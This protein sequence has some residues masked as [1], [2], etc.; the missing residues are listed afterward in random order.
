MLERQLAYWRERLA[1]APP[2]LELPAD[3][4]RPAVQ[5]VARRACARRRSAGWRAACAAFA[6]ASG[7]TPFMVLLAAFEALLLRYTGQDDLVVGTPVAGRGRAETEALIGFFVN[8]LALRVRVAG[9][10][11]FDALLGEVRRVT[12]E[13]FAH[14]DL[15]FEKLV[16]ELAPE[17]S[18]AHAPLFQV[19]LV[20]QNAPLPRLRLGGVELAPL[21]VEPAAAQFDLSLAVGEVEGGARA[22]WTYD[23]DLFDGATVERWMSWFERL[24]A[25]ALAD[26]GRRLA[27]LPLL[28]AAE[29]R[30]LA[31][32]N[33]TAALFPS[34]TCLHELIARQVRRTPAAPAVRFEGRT[35]SY[36]EL[37]GAANRLAHRLQR[38]G[39]G[40]EV[41]V[42]IHAERSLELVVGLL[43]VLKA[44][45]AYVPLDPGYPAE[46][47]A[48]M[49]ADAGVSVL[50]TRGHLPQL[51]HLAH[52]PGRGAE[53]VLL[54]DLWQLDEPASAPASAAGPDSLAYVI[55]TSGSTGRPKGAMNAHRGIVNRL[56]W[57]Q[58]QFDLGAGDRVLQKTPFSFD[59]SVWELFWPLLTGACLVVARPGG[60]QDPGYLVRTIAEEGITTLHF[61]PSMLQVFLEAPGLESCTSL[62]RVLASGEALPFELVERWYARTSVPLHNLY[63]PT[64]AAVDVTHWPCAPADARRLVPIGQ[65][66]WNTRIHLLDRWG[67]EVPVG[68]AGELH[69][70]GVQVGRGYLGRPELTAERFVPDGLGSAPGERQSD[71]NG[72][73]GARESNWNGGLGARLYRT[74]DLARRLPAGEVEYLGRLDFQVKVRGFR[75][76]PG[77]IEAALAA[78]PGVREAVVLARPEPGRSGARL[79]AYLVP[80]AADGAA[81]DG[82]GSAADDLVAALRGGLAERLPEHMVPQAFVVLAELPRSPNG[83][84]DRR[85]L[86]AVGPAPAAP[87]AGGQVAPRTPVEQLLAELWCETLGVEQA[88]VREH[89]FAAGGNSIGGAILINR[90]QERLGVA[91]PVAAI[92]QHPTIEGLAGYLE[93][94]HPRAVVRLWAAAEMAADGDELLDDDEPAAA[95]AAAAEWVVP[96]VLDLAAAPPQALPLSYAQERLWFLDQ[97]DP[98]T[99][100]YNL[101]SALQ[102]SGRL[103][104]AA[105]AGSQCEVVRRHAALR[106]VFTVVDG[107]PC[108]VVTPAR[109]EALPLADLAALPAAARDREVRRLADEEA[110]QP[111]DLARGPLLRTGLLR[112]APDEH[113][114]LLTMHHI[115]SDGWSMGVLIHEVAVL[116]AAEVQ[117]RPSPLH[118]LPIQYADYAVWQRG[119]LQGELLDREL[120]Y[121]R[122]ALAGVPPLQLPTDRPRPAVQSFR[123]GDSPVR[124]A[125]T[126]LTGLRELARAE[127]ATL[128]VVLLAGFQALLARHS[129]QE[130]LS[131]GSPIANRT[132]TEIEGLIGFFLNTLVLRTD[133][134]G[135]PGFR[136]L[137][138]RVRGVAFA[139]YDHQAVPFEKVVQELA[140]ERNLSRTPLFQVL[141]VLQNA[142][143][144]EMRLPGLTIARIEREGG[145]PSST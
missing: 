48:F 126:L 102:L 97:L 68:V 66:V 46:R 54:D 50:L 144:G 3:R 133:L 108:Q 8:T 117:G 135:D 21:P 24:L 10:A 14:Q 128:Y 30:Q 127:Q 15:P 31:G 90:L 26:P 42:G 58:A 73:L 129:G 33:A 12:L 65:P 114:I 5:T 121:W 32:W 134:A 47:L 81:A 105:L 63:G 130:D 125:R 139:A 71:W 80:A 119:W 106:T 51:P 35:L 110:L 55:F 116:Y 11:G 57:M 138:E 118:A 137:L 111:F 34:R 89:F 91:V 76:E 59:V 94:E 95:A 124:T 100:T 120:A 87:A 37:D 141:L 16:E 88:G 83:K 70:G 77:E 98:G 112:L 62:R 38:L 109:R 52:L 93:E 69:I 101:P 85:A 75:I 17:R 92:F 20:L 28:A 140:P 86:A 27:D 60:H 13:A 4:P 136:T 25:G 44:G 53:V 22:W 40:P 61:V 29:R 145:R 7:A 39:V 41:R 23:R 1:G 6:G 36:A 113:V 9:E 56:A 67:T 131:V 82:A 78:Q 2:L 143:M 123:G 99:A 107:R 19:L 104:V 49:L 103:D 96:R 72:G 18:L 132:R 45:G 64:E 79:V 43:A 142:P 74:G 115:V 122:A 84:A